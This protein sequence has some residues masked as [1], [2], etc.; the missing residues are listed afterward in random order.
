MPE[1]L[2]GVF[3]HRVTHPGS[4]LFRGFDDTFLVPHSRHTESDPAAIEVIADRLAAHPE[5][6]KVID[7]V[8]VATS[9]VRL[10]Y[11]IHRS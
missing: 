10:V 1:K 2:F 9:G 3:E 6:A 4:I 8:M 5:I 11:L 7:P